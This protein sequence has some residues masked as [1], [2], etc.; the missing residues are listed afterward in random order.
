MKFNRNAPNR[1]DFDRIF[2]GIKM[3]TFLF[4]NLWNMPIFDVN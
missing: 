2:H 4:L 1:T 3:F